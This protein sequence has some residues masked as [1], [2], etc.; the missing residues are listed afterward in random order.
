VLLSGH[1][2]HDDEPKLIKDWLQA[3]FLLVAD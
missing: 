3:K 1:G 2:L